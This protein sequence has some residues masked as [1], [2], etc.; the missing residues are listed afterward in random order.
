MAVVEVFGEEFGGTGGAGGSEEEGLAQGDFPAGLFRQ[1]GL[2]HGQR[3][4]HH[5][6]FCEV[7]DEL[8]NLHAGHAALLGDVPYVA[9]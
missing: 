9:L 5:G 2:K 4:V 3:V 7:V 1:G 8:T 6:P